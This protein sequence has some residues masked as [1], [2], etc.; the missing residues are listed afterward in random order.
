M[1]KAKIS[2]IIGYKII[3]AP[4]KSPEIDSSGRPTIYQELFS[5]GVNET[6]FNLAAHELQYKMLLSV[7]RAIIDYEIESGSKFDKLMEDN[8]NK[9]LYCDAVNQ[10]KDECRNGSLTAKR[11]KESFM[12]AAMNLYEPPKFKIS[13][14]GSK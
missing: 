13:I 14:N 10:W 4:F 9:D 11:I 5:T 1:K 2:N 3:R 8:V 7:N 12:D 6:N